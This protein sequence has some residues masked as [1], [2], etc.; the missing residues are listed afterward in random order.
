MKRL[1]VFLTMTLLLTSCGGGGGNS[2]AT[3]ETPT[4]TAYYV[5]APVKGLIYEAS[6]SGLSGVTDERGAFNFKKG[7]LVSFYID[8]VNRVYIGKVQPVTG[9]IVNPTI[10]NIYDA[11]VDQ[12]IVTLILFTLDKA[13]PTSSFMDLSGLLL[14]TDTVNKIKNFL[15][16]KEMPNQISD[17][18]QSMQSL[19]AD[20]PNYTFRNSGINLNT[21]NFIKSSFDSVESLDNIKIDVGDFSGVYA[22]N[23]A[24][25]N[26]IHFNFLPNGVVNSFDHDNLNINAGTFVKNE[27]SI[28][29]RWDSRSSDQCDTLMSL[30]KS[31]QQWSLVN[32][33]YA[34]T[35]LGCNQNDLVAY[36]YRS[37]KIS[38]STSVSAISGKRLQIP[39]RGV[40]TLGE[41]DVV[42]YISSSGPSSD[43]RTF[44]MPASICNDNTEITGT[45]SESGIPGVLIFEFDIASPRVK[46]FFSVLERSGRAITQ[47][48]LERTAPWQDSDAIYSTETSF[49][50]D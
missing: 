11:E 42:F 36:P 21:S 9:Q 2:V 37:S 41:G 23:Y 17:A 18:W 32:F 50:L 44:N 14:N 26:N 15:A 25:I 28:T 29:I 4:L 16:R 8:L 22:F 5:D 12:V 39:V 7:D 34:K 13:L 35:P 31:S 24:G 10:D 43:Q 30:K 6:P 33:K 47:L 19:Q 49:L 38:S 46:F 20:I 27:S 48:N 1:L 45:V 3:F 40:C